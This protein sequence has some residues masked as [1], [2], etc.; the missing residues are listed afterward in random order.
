MTAP[1][2]VEGE[3]LYEWLADRAR[4]GGF[5]FSLAGDAEPTTG[6]AFSPYPSRSYVVDTGAF[7]ASDIDGY[8][9]KNADLLVQPEHYLGAWREVRDGVD[10]I[11]LD[12]SVVTRDRATAEVI[13]RAFDQ[14][15]AWDLAAGR[16]VIL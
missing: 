4:E 1:L 12:V 8:I 13:G 6:Y 7:T 9:D 10:K 16:E 3:Q 5:T 15:A 11:W 14:K 2:I